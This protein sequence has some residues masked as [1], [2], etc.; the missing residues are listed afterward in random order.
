[1]TDSTVRVDEID[2]I[3]LFKAALI[4]FAESA[5]VALSSAEADCYRTLLWL[6]TEQSAYWK[7]QQRKR[8]EALVRANEAYRQKA[9][10]KDSSGRTPDTTQEQKAVQLAKRQL[11]EAEQK[12][13][14]VK[15]YARR[16]EKEIENYKGSVQRFA[17]S[18]NA[19]IPR[20]VQRLEQTYQQLAAYTALAA[21]ELGTAAGATSA[22]P[23]E[24]MAQ[25]PDDASMARPEP[26]PAPEPAEKKADAPESSADER[27]ATS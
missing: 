6:Q 2:A 12:I 8:A 20:A 22:A 15:T 27:G 11:E 19:D 3:K 16:L 21:P 4:K 5:N 10:F 18:V 23:G 13:V 25:P 1:M 7:N 9:Y 24:S 26:A 14:A 17:T